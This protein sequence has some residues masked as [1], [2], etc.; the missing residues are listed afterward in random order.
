MLCAPAARGLLAAGMNPV[1]WRQV[2]AAY[3]G[4]RFVPKGPQTQ[5]R[6]RRARTSDRPRP[7]GPHPSKWVIRQRDQIAEAI[8]ALEADVGLP[9]TAFRP[10]EPGPELP[11][12]MFRAAPGRDAPADA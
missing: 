2:A 8:N 11:P 6:P 9:L 1:A 5:G 4:L 3:R 10:S 7:T 12:E